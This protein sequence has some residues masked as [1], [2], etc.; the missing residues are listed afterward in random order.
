MNTHT[1]VT[2]LAPVV[3]TMKT[4]IHVHG[5]QFAVWFPVPGVPHP[6]AWS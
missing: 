3:V 2:L 6:P 4:I 5:S 1:K